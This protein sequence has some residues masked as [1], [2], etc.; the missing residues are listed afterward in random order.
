MIFGTL[1]TQAER[2]RFAA[3][4]GDNAMLDENMRKHFDGFPAHAPPWRSCRR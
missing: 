2:E 3:L 1:P 4:L